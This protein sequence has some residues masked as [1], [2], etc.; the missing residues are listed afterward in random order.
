MRM[1]TWPWLWRR[2][3]LVRVQMVDIVWQRWVWRLLGL[4]VW[5][6]RDR[7]AVYRHGTVS[8]QG[9]PPAGVRVRVERL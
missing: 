4:P 3:Y 9:L 6:Q 1:R 8:W 5:R 2:E 7:Q